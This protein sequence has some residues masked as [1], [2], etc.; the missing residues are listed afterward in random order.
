MVKCTVT[1]ISAANWP[2]LVS[3]FNRIRR[4]SVDAYYDVSCGIKPVGYYK[5]RAEAESVAA[6]YEAKYNKKVKYR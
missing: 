3:E 2:G 1:K 4:A 6:R 5:T